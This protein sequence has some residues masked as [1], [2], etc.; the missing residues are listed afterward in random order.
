[1]APRSQ[2]VDAL[3]DLI[4]WSGR[5]RYIQDWTVTEKLLGLVLPQDY[6]ELLDT[7]PVGKYAGTV[8]LTPPTTA[9]EQGDLLALFREA[10]LRLTDGRRHPYRAY[11]E[12]PG[13]IP[14]AKFSHPMGGQLFWRA[15]RDDPDLWPVVAW[16]ADGSWEEYDV[17]VAQFLTAVVDGA[18]PGS[19]VSRKA[20]APAYR[21]FQDL[22]GAP[23]NTGG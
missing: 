15:D 6:K 5:P 13:L 12:L 8:L 19:V 7:V 1:M 3:V 18:L 17:G 4:G 23:N 11:P 2:A 16:G 20:G 21:T 14:W 10:M 9:G 22:P